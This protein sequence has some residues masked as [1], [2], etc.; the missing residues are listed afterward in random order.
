M[1]FQNRY[2]RTAVKRAH[3]LAV[4]A[5]KRAAARRGFTLVELLVVIAI[6]SMLIGLLL[7]AVAAAKAAARRTQCASNLHN[8]GLGIV[9]YTEAHKGKFPKTSHDSVEESWVFTLDPYV[10]GVNSIRICPDDPKAAERL[11]AKSSSYAMN[12]YVTIPAPG[13]ILRRDKLPATTKTIVVFE[14]ADKSGINEY[15]DHV[16]SYNW[17]KKANV[18]KQLVMQKL[19]DEITTDRHG[20]GSHFLYADG[21]VDL[22]LESQ[23][24]DWAARGE[25][26]VRPP[27]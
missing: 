4:R 21:H 24:A 26:F 13:A 2:A 10:E 5:I 7:P 18:D 19:N 6:M 22:I 23:V 3:L 9:N 17:F 16:H 12:A 11:A 25:N 14:L 8:L 1:N 27:K 15:L 20:G